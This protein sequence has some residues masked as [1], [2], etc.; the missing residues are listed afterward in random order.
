MNS[1]SSPRGENEPSP[2][3]WG[4]KPRGREERR[5]AWRRGRWSEALCRLALRLKGYRILASGF[6][7]PVGEI[8]IVA[9][10]GTFLVFVEVKAR[11]RLDDAAEAI[12]AHQRRRIVRAAEAFLARNPRCARLTPRFDVMLVSPLRAPRHL[13]AAWEAE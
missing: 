3:A 1:G 12:G 5:R 8:D 6:R 13:V 4:S 2:R 10:R 7:V 9:E 11:R